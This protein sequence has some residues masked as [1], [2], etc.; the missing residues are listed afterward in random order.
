M[1]VPRLRERAYALGERISHHY[2]DAGHMMYTRE[3]DLRKL[4]QDLAAWWP[5][6][7]DKAAAG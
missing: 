7:E 2:Y 6:R 4:H 5:S 1:Q 3:A